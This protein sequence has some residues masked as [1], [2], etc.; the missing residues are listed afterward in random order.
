M[1]WLMYVLKTL[2]GDYCLFK[3]L[4]M[5][6]LT[7]RTITVVKTLSVDYGLHAFPYATR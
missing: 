7:S 4:I 3:T 5:Y 2:F 6:I 1:L